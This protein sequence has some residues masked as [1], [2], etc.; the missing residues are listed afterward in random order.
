MEIVMTDVHDVIAAFADGEPVDPHALKAALA[1]PDGRDYLVDVLALRGLVS[2]RGVS[3]ARASS[4][5]AAMRRATSSPARW[6][7][8]AAILFV[9]LLSGF[10]VG[11][12]TASRGADSAPAVERVI[13]LPASP[14]AAPEPTQVIRFQSGVDWKESAGGN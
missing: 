7:P 8:A 6:M 2:G 1:M 11:W 5:S 13:D 9:S 4:A 14:V 12:R 3:V 10:A